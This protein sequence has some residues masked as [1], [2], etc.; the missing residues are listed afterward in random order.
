MSP[1]TIRVDTKQMIFPFPNESTF[2]G[3][4]YVLK[5]PRSFHLSLAAWH[6]CNIFRDGRHQIISI[7]WYEGI[8][9][10]KPHERVV[11][12]YCMYLGKTSIYKISNFPHYPSCDRMS[13][14]VHS[15]ARMHDIN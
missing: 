2:A 14:Q 4:T 1:G 5:T 6:Y 7:F 3:H 15:P 8:I 9:V 13:V 12:M 11:S 10:Y